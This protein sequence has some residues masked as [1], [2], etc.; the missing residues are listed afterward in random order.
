MTRD[1]GPRQLQVLRA[2]VREGVY[3]GGWYYG[4]HSTTV[5][6]LDSLVKRGLVRTEERQR[7]VSP[8][9]TSGTYTIYLPTDEGRSTLDVLLDPRREVGA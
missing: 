8:R 6:V 9:I 3:P 1:L 5:T 2:L 4:N 7:A